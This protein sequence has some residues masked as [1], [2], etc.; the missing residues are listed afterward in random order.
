MSNRSRHFTSS[1]EAVVT[2]GKPQR[3]RPKRDVIA[4]FEE[5]L[6]KSENF[7]SHEEMSATNK[8]QP[9]NWETLYQNIRQM[10]SA[11]DAPVDTVG[12]EKSFDVNA[13]PKDQ[14]FQALVS[15]MLSSQTKDEINNAAVLRLRNAGLSPDMIISI[16]DDKLGDLI[17]P[18]GFWRKKIVY[19][20]K[21]CH[22]IKNEYNGD[23]PDTVEGLC[24]L[25]GVGPKMAHLVMQIAWNKITGIAVDT[26][27]HR[28][29]NRL[30]FVKKPTKNPIDTERELEDWIPRDLWKE[31][32]S[33]IVGFGQT[34]C[35]P[36]NPKCS[37][38]LN[39]NLCPSSSAKE[40][41]K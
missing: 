15:L 36:V 34:I 31:F 41:K 28:I 14:R 35:V 25:P 18:V 24:S 23:I 22:I 6:E 30:K 4:A 8:W 32:N 40:R 26:H 17:K 27:V 11:G 1:S 10:R 20:K 29:S 21:A 16:D 39:R 13:S 12:C 3:K 7:V 5:T 37:Q 9:N 19:L 2:E 38:C 33:L